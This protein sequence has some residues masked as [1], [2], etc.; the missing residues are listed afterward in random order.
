MGRGGGV[1]FSKRAAPCEEG[2]VQVN[3]H[4]LWSEGFSLQGLRDECA[5]SKLCVEI[6]ALII[7]QPCQPA[8]GTTLRTGPQIVWMKVQHH[9]RVLLQ[10]ADLSQLGV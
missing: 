7:A 1:T 5:L 3:R 4:Q 6:A 8:L 2:Q 10:Q 9:Q